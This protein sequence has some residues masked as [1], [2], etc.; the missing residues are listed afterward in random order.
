MS[1]SSRSRVTE[2]R[3]ELERLHDACKDGNH[4]W[5]EEKLTFCSICGRLKEEEE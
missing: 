2:S 5:E 1:S 4:K 3:E